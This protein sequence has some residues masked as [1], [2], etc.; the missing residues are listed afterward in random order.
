MR[1]P[2]SCSG[3][4]RPWSFGCRWMGDGSGCPGVW[5]D[6]GDRSYAPTAAYPKPTNFKRPPIDLA[7][8]GDELRSPESSLRRSIQLLR[9]GYLVAPE[10]SRVPE[11]SISLSWVPPIYSL[12]RWMITP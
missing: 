2:V 3:C 9:R 11:I 8:I 6:P 4:R 5:L 10:V 7:P 12:C 1:K